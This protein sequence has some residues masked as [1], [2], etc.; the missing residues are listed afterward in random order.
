MSVRHAWVRVHSR[1][2]YLGSEAGA[3]R[4]AAIMIQAAARAHASRLDQR[5]LL[6]VR[7]SPPVAQGG[8]TRGPGWGARA[9]RL[10]RARR[11]AAWRSSRRWCVVAP[12]L[13]QRSAA[14]ASAALAELALRRASVQPP[15]SIE[16][17]SERPPA[18]AVLAAAGADEGVSQ[19]GGRARRRTP[20]QWRQP[21]L[22][23]SHQRTRQQ[24]R[25]PR[26]RAAA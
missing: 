20:R 23:Q 21:S 8:G 1:G 16:R 15:P 14:G 26:L 2:D 13:S 3:R 9:W 4:W 12:L 25:H 19:Q 10:W 17:R 18:T 6:A 22:E 24:R 7:L 5:G 11:G